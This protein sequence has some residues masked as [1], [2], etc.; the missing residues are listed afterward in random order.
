MSTE[1]QVQII[2]EDPA[3]EAYKLGLLNR[4]KVLLTSP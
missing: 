4:L 3:I 2:R 1:T